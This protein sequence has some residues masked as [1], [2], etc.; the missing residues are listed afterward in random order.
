[1]NILLTAY[2]FW[3]Y[4]N[5]NRRAFKEVSNDDDIEHSANN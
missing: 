4:E 1:M 3:Q 2:E 5:K